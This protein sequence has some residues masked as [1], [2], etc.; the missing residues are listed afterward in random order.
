MQ[1][2]TGL[3]A[4][5]SPSECVEGDKWRFLTSNQNSTSASR[6]FKANAWESKQG[7]YEWDEWEQLAHGR[8]YDSGRDNGMFR[9]SI[10]ESR[11]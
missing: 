4:S 6:F 2:D 5:G 10:V 8:V 7:P 9:Q 1:P 3:Q 11:R